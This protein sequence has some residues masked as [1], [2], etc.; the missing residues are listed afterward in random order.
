MPLSTKHLLALVGFL[1]FGSALAV[2]LAEGC[3]HGWILFSGCSVMLVQRAPAPDGGDPR[4]PVSCCGQAAESTAAGKGHGQ[5][6]GQPYAGTRGM[7]RV[8]ATCFRRWTHQVTAWTAA[9]DGWRGPGLLG[10]I[11]E[12]Q[13]VTGLT[14]RADAESAKIRFVLNR[15]SPISSAFASNPQ[16]ERLTAQH[17]GYFRAF[18][19][20]IS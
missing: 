3:A 10:S 5:A 2:T 12:S 18:S 1:V 4:A 9:S 11:N 19:P 13:G 7:Y 14:V 8:V 6:C 15:Q 20:A 16:P 17:R